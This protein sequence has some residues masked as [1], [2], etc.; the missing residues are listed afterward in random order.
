MPFEP[1]PPTP[2]TRQDEGAI[3]AVPSGEPGRTDTPTSQRG[4]PSSPDAPEPGRLSFMHR[5]FTKPVVTDPDDGRTSSTRRFSFLA[6]GT[7][8]TAAAVLVLSLA[9]VA[10]ALAVTLNH[11]AHRDAR[12]KPLGSSTRSSPIRA[13]LGDNF[14]DPEILYHQGMWYAFATNNA[15]GIL[16]RPENASSYEY[17]TSNVQIAT[18]TDFLRWDLLNSSHDPLP[19]VGAWANT[20]LTRLSPYIPRANVWAPAVIQRPTDNKF[21]MYYSATQALVIESWQYRRPPAHCIGAA[22]SR[23]DSPAGPYDP[24]DTFLACDVV[25]G[26]AIDPAA[27]K[28]KDGTLY[29][30]YKIDGNNI[31]HGGSCGNTRAPIMPTPIMLQKMRPD[32]VTAD[33][34]P[35]QILDRTKADGP[36][37]EAPALVRAPDGTCFLFFSS[38]C[39]RSSSYDVKYATARSI[40]GPYTRA[41]RP[42][43]QSGDFGLLAPGSVGIHEDGRGSYHMAFQA[44]ISSPQGRIRAL[45]TTE[46]H[47]EGDSARLEMDDNVRLEQI[48]EQIV[49]GGR[50]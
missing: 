48:S 40:T 50:V 9:V 26:G 37:V 33:G 44:R 29:V 49:S 28:D 14:P 5:H 34:R 25:L 20:G 42:L 18:S 19:K 21:V 30:A 36:L 27:F 32:G 8:V 7:L 12:S 4:E 46:L 6:R 47:L 22:V 16:K 15:A 43:L 3:N 24:I 41:K 39:T 10:I 1:S 38:G 45:F 17:G 2:R 23:T 31:G 13:A 11:H 35:V